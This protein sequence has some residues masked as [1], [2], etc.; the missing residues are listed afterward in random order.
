MVWLYQQCPILVIEM[1]NPLRSPERQLEMPLTQPMESSLAIP[2]AASLSRAKMCTRE[3]NKPPKDCNSDLEGIEDAHFTVSVQ[4]LGL[5]FD[6]EE[7]GSVQYTVLLFS[8]R[9]M[10]RIKG[11]LFIE[12]I[13]IN[14]S[15]DL[16]RS[17]R[18]PS[19]PHKP[20]EP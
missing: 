17:P 2:W 6:C 11:F 7:L 19:V 9:E 16:D 8:P 4:K 12:P 14:K 13:P 5:T 10:S 1:L 18:N 15:L 20:E 3:A